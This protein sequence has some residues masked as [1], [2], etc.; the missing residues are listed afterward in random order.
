MFISKKKYH[1]DLA[2]M[3]KAT[4]AELREEIEDLWDERD[5]M[6]LE[7]AELKDDVCHLR[8]EVA[9]VP[10]KTVSETTMEPGAP[11]SSAEIVDQWLNGK[12]DEE[13]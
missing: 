7:I 11:L 13:E 2:L 4:V 1:D 8:E 10:K 9:S 5:R 12:E 3:A 6:A